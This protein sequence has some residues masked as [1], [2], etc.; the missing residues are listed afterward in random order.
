LLFR[1][2]ATEDGALRKKAHIYT[3]DEHGID[4]AVVDRD[5]LWI[6]RRLRQA[7]FHAYIVGG[8][9]RDLLTARKPKDFDVATDAH[10]QQIRRLFRSARL[11]GRRFRLVHV[12]SSP[13]KY[14]EV[15]TFRSRA[16]VGDATHGERDRRGHETAHAN[17]FGTMEEDA[18]RRDFTINALY[19]CPIDRQVIDYVGGFPDIRQ[20]RL[21]TLLPADASFAEDP[22]RMIRAA[23]YA[24]LLSFPIPLSMAGLI[25]RASGALLTCSRERVTEEVFKILTS[26]GAAEILEL[27][28]RLRVFDTIL[29]AVAA[30]LKAG[31]RRFADSEFA[32]RLAALD[33][34][35]RA[36]E[37][38]E[39][40]EMF[41]F[42]FRD[43]MLER[44]DLAAA[45]DP[46]FVFQQMLRTISAPLFPSR[47]DLAT[48]ERLVLGEMLPHRHPGAH[49]EA[50]RGHGPAAP[51]EHRPGGRRRRR[52]G[53]RRHRR[54]GS[55]HAPV[56]RPA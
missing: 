51:G 4:P 32:R 19:Y 6:V 23:K 49:G 12:Y 28:L 26:G 13:Q 14:I 20:K 3:Q 24:S 50:R 33:G 35:A 27:C 40:S 55:G 18:E 2:G 56:P 34:K 44:D 25:R 30:W 41:A 42:L 16:A 54:G 11:I 38:L 7:G 52:R 53:G 17:L 8:A 43:V 21:R 22:V 10:P 9:I 47:R 1:Y 29:P 15:S 48:A 37:L 45:E 31:R 46:G 36:G 5:A 39:R